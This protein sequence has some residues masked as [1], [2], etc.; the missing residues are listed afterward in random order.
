MMQVSQ[1]II[2]YMLNLFSAVLICQLYLNKTGRKISPALI[3]IC[4]ESEVLI[5][6]R[7]T[8]EFKHS[9]FSGHI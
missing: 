2:L 8:G 7:D 5:G 9:H 6:V 3:S 1:T 4:D